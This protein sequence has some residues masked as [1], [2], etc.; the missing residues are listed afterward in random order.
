MK[1]KIQVYIGYPPPPAST[2]V[3]DSHDFWNSLFLFCFSRL[4]FFISL[5]PPPLIKSR[6]YVPESEE[7]FA[8]WYSMS[9]FSFYLLKFFCIFD[10]NQ[11]AKL[12]H[13]RKPVKT[14]YATVC[15]E[16]KE[17]N[18]QTISSLGAY[19]KYVTLPSTSL[20]IFRVLK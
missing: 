9:S 11:K 13:D 10:N 2:T 14:Y 15:Q 8:L 4:F 17:E 6:C 18:L 12:S 7:S 20:N 5:P 19:V 1:L 16:N 3:Q